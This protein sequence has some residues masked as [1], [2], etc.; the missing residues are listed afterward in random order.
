MQ[1][2]ALAKAA[3][4][5]HDSDDEAG[6]DDN[7]G[8]RDDNDAPIEMNLSLMEEVLDSFEQFLD[9]NKED[10]NHTYTKQDMR[11]LRFLVIYLEETTDRLKEMCGV[12]QE[13][14]R[15]STTNALSNG[16]DS[17]KKF[18]KLDDVKKMLDELLPPK[19][20]KLVDKA[21]SQAQGR[22]D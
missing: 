9:K 21:I 1:Q 14:G 11:K 19:L 7:E 3:L 22:L 12:K 13:E 20:D 2:A 10:E 4:A 15:S 17:D 6:K 18:I 16:H 5:A 8:H